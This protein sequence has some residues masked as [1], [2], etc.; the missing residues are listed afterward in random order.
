M[1]SKKHHIIEIA[2][3]L[4]Y[5]KGIHA[6]AINEVINCSESAKKSIAEIHIN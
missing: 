5:E 4:F 1:N 2:F 3:V 6:V